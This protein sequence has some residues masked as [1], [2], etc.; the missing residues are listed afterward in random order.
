MKRLALA[1]YFLL[2]LCMLLDVSSVP[3]SAGCGEANPN[4]IMPD[5]PP[6][7]A[8]FAAANTRFVQQ[9]IG[10]GGNLPLPNAKIYVGNVS[11]F[12][13]PVAMSNDCTIA[14]TGAVTCTK[15]NGVSFGAL[16][17]ENSITPS[18]CPTF[19]STQPGCVPL[20]GGGTTNFL[21]ADGNW[22]PSSGGVSSF[23]GLTGAIA[24]A[25]ADKRVYVSIAGNDSNTGLSPQSAKLTLQACVNAANPGGVCK[26]GAGTYTLTSSLAMQP[27]VRLQCEPVTTITQG[28]A[29]N[30]SAIVDFNANTA[31]AASITGCTVDQNRAN[32]TLNS[33]G[34]VI[35][36]GAANNILIEQNT[37][38]NGTTMGVRVT[39][40]LHP[41]IRNN[42]IQN[43]FYAGIFQLT[44]TT[45]S[46]PGEISG[47]T[48][49][50]ANAHAII[51]E[52]ASG[53]RIH[54]NSIT[55]VLLTGLAI[56]TAG[57]NTITSISGATFSNTCSASTICPGN[58]VIAGPPGP[59]QELFVTNILSSTSANVTGVT[60]NASGLAA[61]AGS[62]DLIDV[63][64]VSGNTD[65]YNNTLQNSAG[66]GLVDAD[67]GDSSNTG[68]HQFNKYRGNSISSI[69]GNCIAVEQSNGADSIFNTIILGNTLDNC[70]DGGSG[71]YGAGESPASSIFLS[72]A[73]VTNVWMTG[74]SVFDQIGTTPFWLAAVGL[75]NGTV[76]TGKN[77]TLG[78]INGT[79]VGGNASAVVEVP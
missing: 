10:G 16:A 58:F 7:D 63:A 53:W 19:S 69:G 36:I 72:G 62:G 61:I 79:T 1:S 20:S 23:E 45:V 76:R 38:Q 71:I 66:G 39:T 2:A 67:A 11:G 31:T 74:N 27:G 44:T 51:V 34:E 13:A 73:N 14:N 78:T 57:S 43:N 40:G 68:T 47:N 12:A 6:G 52:G 21:R 15:T 5:R 30:L 3:A 49:L 22:V 56:T 33:G 9:T 60:D 35:N 54:D 18:Q 41:I 75:A 29:A 46:S 37:I 26:V 55:G 25:S 24:A 32:N 77:F 4:C 70:L 64:A 59:F 42:L 65:V 8:T 28:S 48:F 50:Q 17:T